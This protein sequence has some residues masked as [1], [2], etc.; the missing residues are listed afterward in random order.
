MHRQTLAVP[1]I[2]RNL[3]GFYEPP[4]DFFGVVLPPVWPGELFKKC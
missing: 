1:Y 3:H 4:R 2:A